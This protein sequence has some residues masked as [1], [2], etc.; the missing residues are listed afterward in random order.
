MRS[1]IHP[2]FNFHYSDPKWFVKVHPKRVRFHK[3]KNL[4]MI[5]Y[6]YIRMRDL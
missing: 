1:L 3:L 6:C 5:E 4:Q 2:K